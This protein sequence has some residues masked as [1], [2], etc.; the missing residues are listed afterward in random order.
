MLFLLNGRGNKEVHRKKKQSEIGKGASGEEPVR[1]TLAVQEVENR[2][3][4]G[5]GDA[6]VKPQSGNPALRKYKYQSKKKQ[7]ATGFKAHDA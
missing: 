1:N 7:T 4:E 6:A 2:A 5:G 3:W